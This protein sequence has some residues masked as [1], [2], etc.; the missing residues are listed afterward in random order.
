M[1][2]D[3]WRA[4]SNQTALSFR[5]F[6]TIQ[7]YELLMHTETT[8]VLFCINYYQNFMHLTHMLKFKTRKQKVAGS[9]LITALIIMLLQI[10]PNTNQ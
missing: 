5:W 4:E 3:V 10:S 7:F 1:G 8:M 2:I 9:N 6:V